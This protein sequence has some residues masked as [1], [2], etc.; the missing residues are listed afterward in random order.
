MHHEH[1]IDVIAAGIIALVVIGIVGLQQDPLPVITA[2]DLAAHPPHYVRWLPPGG[3]LNTCE[4]F[5]ICQ[6]GA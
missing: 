5:D 2:P 6:E 4:L 3:E 1:F